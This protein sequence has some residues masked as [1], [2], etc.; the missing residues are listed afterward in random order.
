MD[1]NTGRV[2]RAR[3]RGATEDPVRRLL[4]RWGIAA[5]SP[6]LC[7]RWGERSPWSA[8]GWEK[9]LEGSS[10]D[11]CSRVPFA[12]IDSRKHLFNKRCQMH[13]YLI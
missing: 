9:G 6:S 11:V 7:C 10:L 13:I 3:W 1:W 2:W 8:W 4:G 5:T 12:T